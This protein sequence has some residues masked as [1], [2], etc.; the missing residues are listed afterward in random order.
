M[1]CKA[2]LPTGVGCGAFGT[3][4][5]TGLDRDAEDPWEL[6]R[7]LK[8]LLRELDAL[9]DVERGILYSTCAGEF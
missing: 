4:G 1:G 3:F 7:E 9:E 6:G 2:G 5:V 8:E